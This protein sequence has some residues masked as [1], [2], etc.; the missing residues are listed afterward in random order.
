M[1]DCYGE[2][3]ALSAPVAGQWATPREQCLVDAAQGHGAG[4]NQ[5]CGSEG[6]LQSVLWLAYGAAVSLKAGISSSI[7]HGAGTRSSSQSEGCLSLGWYKELQSVWRLAH[8]GGCLSLGWHK[9]QQQ[10]LRLAHEGG[11]LSLGWHKEQQ[12]VLRLA[13]DGA[14][15]L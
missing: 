5:S 14:V 9:E 11:C 2:R 7:S 13:L 12:R 8:E 4:S 1:H 10:V 3:E 15:F 6:K